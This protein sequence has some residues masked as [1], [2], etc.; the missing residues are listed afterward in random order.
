MTTEAAIW[1]IRRDL[2]LTDNPALSSALSQGS[3]VIPVFILDETLIES[4][5]SGRKRL[6]FLFDGLRDLQHEINQRGGRLII[7]RGNPLAVLRNLLAESRARQVFAEH[8]FSPYARA[9][10]GEL[11]NALPLTLHS[12]P[13]VVHPDDVMKDDGDPYTVFTPYARKWKTVVD[14]PPETIPAPSRFATPDIES[15][16]IP[17]SPRLPESVPFAAGA[18]AGVQRLAGFTHGDQAPIYRY[19]HERDRLDLDSTSRL[20]PYLKFGMVSARQAVAAA[21]TA[22]EAAQDTG[23]RE[24]AESWLNELIWRE[25]YAAILHH[26]PHVRQLEF[27]EKHRDLDWLNDPEDLDAWS[28]AQ[29]GYPIVDASIRQLHAEGWMHN[30]GRMITAS[31]LVKHLLVDWRF[32]EAHFMQHLID[33]DPASNNGG[34]QWTAGTGNDAAPYFRIFNPVLQS[35]RHD[36][37]GT[38]I[39]TW[40]PELDQ[41][42]DRHIHEPWKMSD[43]AQ[44][45]ARCRIGEDYPAPIIDH[46]F[47]RERALETYRRS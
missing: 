11:V 36:P 8:D 32:G 33:G 6:A 42:P 7:R 17:A 2:R 10:D 29:T 5:F 45:Q 37:D 3:T 18:R 46:G 14:S 19:Q 23:G 40:I 27:Q 12:H 28:S 38:F 13:T 47:A 39:R 15:L 4:R 25:F 35:K 9:R 22:I 30:R 31:F 26:F 34:W 20:S 21:M 16:D 43:A 1:W 24:S 41:V 44:R